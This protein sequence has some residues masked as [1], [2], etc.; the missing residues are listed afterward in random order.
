VGGERES[1]RHA[2]DLDV[3]CAGLAEEDHAIKHVLVAGPDW[4]KAD[5]REEDVVDGVVV[6]RVGAG[7]VLRGVGEGELVRV[8]VV[9]ALALRVEPH[10]HHLET[11]VLLQLPAQSHSNLLHLHPIRG[12]LD[13]LLVDRIKRGWLQTP[14]LRLCKG[15]DCALD[16][17]NV[18]GNDRIPMFLHSVG[19]FI[20]DVD[21]DVSYVFWRFSIRNR[22]VAVVDLCCDWRASGFL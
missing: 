12:R 5:A 14:V 22:P 2:D 8:L 13:L 4:R 7:V 16:M 6:S 1:V 3:V 10:K 18:D 9:P 20:A 21:K 11:L 15:L 17:V 19:R